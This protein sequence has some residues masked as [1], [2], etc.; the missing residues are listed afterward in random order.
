MKQ[1][2]DRLN[3]EHA[4]LHVARP[5]AGLLQQR[6]DGCSRSLHEL[7]GLGRLRHFVRARALNPV[8]CTHGKIIGRARGKAVHRHR[9]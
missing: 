8:I 3:G 7:C 9:R 6:V 1:S 4:R 2:V 5:R